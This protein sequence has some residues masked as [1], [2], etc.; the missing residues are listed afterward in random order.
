[1]HPLAALIASLDPGDA[2]WGDVLFVTIW[3][4]GSLVLA[5]YYCYRSFLAR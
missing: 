1:M 4:V 3:A 2:G 5:A